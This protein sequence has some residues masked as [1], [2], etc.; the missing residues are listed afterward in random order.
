MAI[1][2]FGSDVIVVSVPTRLR[3]ADHVVTISVPLI[4]VIAGRSFANLVLRV[5]SAALNGDELVLSDA[6]TALRSRN[7]YFAFADQHLS[8]IVSSYQN[9]K[10]GFAPLGANG[11]VRSIDF[12]VRIAALVDGVV[13]HPV[14]KLNLNLRAREL[15]DVSLRMLSEAKRVGIVKFKFGARLVAGR[16]PVASEH[17][18]IDHS[19]RP[20][21]GVATLCGHVAVNQTDA[22]DAIVFHRSRRVR[23]RAA[24]AWV[25]GTCVVGTSRRSLIHRIVIH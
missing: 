18:S 6:C 3:V 14:S 11:N 9:S 10:T 23:S 8:V 19:R 2:I 15:S 12:R 25:T 13:R 22:R 5:R 1:E 24:G 17:G 7:L 21:L 4:E 16:N 20:V